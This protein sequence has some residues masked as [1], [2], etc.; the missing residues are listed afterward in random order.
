MSGSST[1]PSLHHPHPHPWLRC[2]S[3]WLCAAAARE[4]N[5][6]CV[7]LVPPPALQPDSQLTL[8]LDINDYSMAKYVRGHFQ[9]R[10]APATCPSR[11]GA[12]RG[13][14]CP[15][16]GAAVRFG[17]P[18]VVPWGSSGAGCGVTAVLCG[19][20]C[21]PCPPALPVGS[22]VSRGHGDPAEVIGERPAEHSW[23][24]NAGPGDP[25]RFVPWPWPL[26]VFPLPLLPPL[27]LFTLHVS[28]PP[29]FPTASHPSLSL[30]KVLSPSHISTLS[31]S[32]N[33]HP[34]YLE[35]STASPRVAAAGS[36]RGAG[37]HGCGCHH[38]SR[39]LGC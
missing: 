29:G 25:G 37:S 4:V 23:T 27:P 13:P 24:P 2:R 36:P 1:A 7:V 34:Q 19:A 20:G 8:P 10:V 14:H 16:C 38:R 30:H 15:G 3:C 39:P 35:H 9:V 12:H 33:L 5:A 6:G 21:G 28:K 26:C 11:Q 17:V 18:K 32:Q 22:V 31:Q